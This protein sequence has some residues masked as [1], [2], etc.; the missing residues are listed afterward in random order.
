VFGVVAGAMFVSAEAFLNLYPP[1]AYSFCL[2]CH[3]RDL[4]NGVLNFFF[5]AGFQTAAVSRRALMVSSPAVL[6]GAYLAAR[7]HGERRPQGGERPLRS[8]A[9]G[10]VVM[11]FGIVI[12]GCPTRLTVRAAYGD[13][14]GLLGVAGMFFGVWCG[15]AAMRAR[16]RFGAGGRGT[17]GGA[18]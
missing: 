8:C 2:A 6:M 14:Y 16:F 5:S 4:V 10:F 9:T 1:A 12:F 15:T 7:I 11:V 3:T 13:V 18:R 17:H